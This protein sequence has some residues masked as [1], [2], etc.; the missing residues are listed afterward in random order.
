MKALLTKVFA[1]LEPKHDQY[2]QNVDELLSDHN[3]LN[4]LKHLKQ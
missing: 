1:F 2:D 4:P 3:I